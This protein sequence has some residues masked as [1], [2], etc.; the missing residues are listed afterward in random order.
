MDFCQ[1]T[2]YKDCT[3]FDSQPQCV[4]ELIY[5]HH[6]Q[7]VIQHFSPCSPSSDELYVIKI[8]IYILLL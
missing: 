2:F 6:C 1:I 8:Y 5:P 4:R 3:S 7:R